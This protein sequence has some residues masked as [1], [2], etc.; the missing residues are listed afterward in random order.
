MSAHLSLHQTRFTP[1]G[2]RF[3]VY[4]LADSASP[5]ALAAP[6]KMLVDAGN[7]GSETFSDVATFAEAAGAGAVYARPL[8][9]F[10]DQGDGVS[11]PDVVTY[12]A[13]GDTLRVLNPPAE[14]NVSAAYLDFIIVAAPTHDPAGLA[15][16]LPPHSVV[17]DPASPFPW[18]VPQPPADV[19]G[20]AWKLIRAG[21]DV[22]GGTGAP[23]LGSIVHGFGWT[24]RL[25]SSL[26]PFAL[27]DRATSFY[28]NGTDA[29]NHAAAVQ[30][31][32]RHVVEQA[33][34]DTASY[35]TADF[36]PNPADITY[37]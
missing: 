28:D 30:L 13:V 36:G 37:T 8:T 1:D 29:L 17:V 18:S 11:H 9:V 21:S 20:L 12:A 23:A 2:V 22:T 4:D 35:T 6:F 16:S 34:V 19:P 33:R 15:Y 25:F 24:Q 26:G 10:T 3:G 5:A 27:A 7:P 31:K 14:W 32:L